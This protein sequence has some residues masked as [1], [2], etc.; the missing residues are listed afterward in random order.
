MNKVL[1]LKVE[2]KALKSREREH[3]GVGL[4]DV[5]VQNV[6]FSSL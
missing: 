5:Y 3:N 6:L 1:S 2:E 4:T